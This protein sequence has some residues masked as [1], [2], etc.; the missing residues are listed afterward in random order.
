[1]ISLRYA[2]PTNQQQKDNLILKKDLN[3]HFSKEY[4]QMANNHMKKCQISIAIRKT[5]IKTTVNTSCQLLG[6]LQSKWRK[7]T[8]DGE[9]VERFALSYNAGWNLM[10]LNTESPCEPVIPLLVHPKSVNARTQQVSV[11][12]GSKQHYSQQPK[13]R[14]HKYPPAG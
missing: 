13:G 3:R 10:V 4:I 6:W 14:N 8:S 11:H 2:C 1:M 9:E 5:Q 7:T 12:P